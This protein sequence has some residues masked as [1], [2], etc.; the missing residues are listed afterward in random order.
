[1]KIPDIIGFKIG[2]AKKIL[3][4]KGICISDVKVTSPP[5]EESTEYNENYRIIRFEIIDDKKIGL[6]VC[7]PDMN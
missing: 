5:R 4:S 3:D 6:L 7:N 2:D 1:M